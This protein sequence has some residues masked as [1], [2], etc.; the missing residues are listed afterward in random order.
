MDWLGPLIRNLQDS[1]KNIALVIDRSS[2]VTH[3]ALEDAADNLGYSIVALD[4]YQSFRIQYESEYRN[5]WDRGESTEKLL[6]L[7]AENRSVIPYDIE[8][9]SHV[10]EFTL[11]S[12]F[13]KLNIAVL[14]EISPVFYPKA[15]DV[16]RSLEEQSGRLSKKQTI[17]YLCRFV[18]GFDP[19]AVTSIEMLISLMVDIFL[20]ENKMPDIITD[21]IVNQYTKMIP[22]GVDFRSWFGSQNSFLGWLRSEW[23]K[24]LKN[25]LDLGEAGSIDFSH[26]NLKI[27]SIQLMSQSILSKIEL[28]DDKTQILEKLSKEDSWLLL[29]ISEKKVTRKTTEVINLDKFDK[30]I[31]KD[32]ET[33]RSLSTIDVDSFLVKTRKTVESVVNDLYASTKN[34]DTSLA[35]YDKLKVLEATRILPRTTA[36]FFHTLRILGNIG[37]HDT[38]RLELSQAEIETILGLVTRVLE[39]Y[40]ERKK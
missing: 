25:K 39:W 7:A 1:K 33:L 40:Q 5:K 16:E 28:P 4:N 30:N 13:K 23:D 22:D 26:S 9:K 15:Y 31:Q 11:D 34:P 10:I 21:H 20:S 6:I 3:S 38:K 17:D 29:G 18:W 32:L 12:I 14:E 27:K 35:L 2:V 37:A 19:L 36:T 24:Y 8:F